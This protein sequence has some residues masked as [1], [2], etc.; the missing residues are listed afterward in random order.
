MV[1]SQPQ[2]PANARRRMLTI[3]IPHLINVTTLAQFAEKKIPLTLF[4][5]IVPTLRSQ[6]FFPVLPRTN[7]PMGKYCPPNNTPCQEYFFETVFNIN[8]SNISQLV[9]IAPNVFVTKEISP[10]LGKNCN[11]IFSGAPYRVQKD[12]GCYTQRRRDNFP[13]TQFFLDKLLILKKGLVQGIPKQLA[14][15]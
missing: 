10:I 11:Q 9:D 12:Q 7:T 6:L 13:G 8:V 4:L 14:E 3:S 5:H 15:S 2:H 1:T